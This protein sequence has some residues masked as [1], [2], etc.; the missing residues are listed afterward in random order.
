MPLLTG[1]PQFFP[2]WRSYGRAVSPGTA[3]RTASWFAA[4]FGW[5]FSEAADRGNWSGFRGPEGGWALLRDISRAMGS[6][7]RDLRRRVNFLWY[8]AEVTASR[9]RVHRAL[10][11]T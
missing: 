6:E 5:V 3:S 4:P 1:S 8:L 7:E 2:W 11:D 9:N 10:F